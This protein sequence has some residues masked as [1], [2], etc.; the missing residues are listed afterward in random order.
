MSILTDIF[1]SAPA[2]ARKY[3]ALRAG[4]R[5]GSQFEVAEFNRL[6]NL[7]FGTLWAII[8]GEEFDFDKHALEKMA[9]AADT[10]LFGFPA[11][12]VQ[13]LAALTEPT[14]EEVAEAW[15]DTEELQ[16]EPDEAQ[17]VVAEMVR[18]AKLACATSKGLFFWGS[19]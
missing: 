2:D 10:W 17:E 16:W 1:V 7:E 3:E 13:A 18:L 5:L 11:K 14:I 19:L 4:G 12:Y 6:T 8:Q 15:A 9:P